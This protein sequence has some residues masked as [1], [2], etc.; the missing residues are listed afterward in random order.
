M[1]FI[2]YFD[3]NGNAV[4]QMQYGRIGERRWLA[5]YDHGPCILLG[6]NE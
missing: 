6:D 1:H 5:D 4:M 2:G 3:L